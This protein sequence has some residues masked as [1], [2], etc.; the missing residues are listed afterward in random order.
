MSNPKSRT[1]CWTCRLRHKK[2]DGP[3]PVCQSCKSLQISCFYGHDKPNWMDNGNMQHNMAQQIKAEVRRSATQRRGRRLIQSIAQDMGDAGHDI[4]SQLDQ[5]RPSLA[6]SPTSVDAGSSA[7]AG[8]RQ[9]TAD[10]SRADFLFPN[11]SIPVSSQGG[12]VPDATTNSIP[13]VSLPVQNVQHPAPVIQNEL[14]LNLVMAYLDYVFPILFPFYRPS[15]LEGGRNWLLVLLMKNKGLCHTVISLTTYF[16]SIVPAIQGQAH[17]LCTPTMWEE[18][19]KQTDLAIKMMQNDLQ[20]INRQGVHSDLHE[21]A[22]LMESIVQLLGFE[23]IFT[24]TDSWQ[25]HLDAAIVLFVQIFQRHG[26]KELP[27]NISAILGQMGHKSFATITSNP[28]LPTL[29]N[30]DQ[31]AFRFFSAILLV[32]DIISSTSLEK[33]PRLH[34]YHAH[35]L[36]NDLNHDQ[37]VP[38]QIEDLV[39]C[40]SWAILLI[41][42][43]ATLDAW[44]KDMK[45]CDSLPMAQLVQRAGVIERHLYE[46]LERLDNPDSRQ[47]PSSKHFVPIDMLTQYKLYNHQ[48][49]KQDAC[50]SIT[51]IWAHAA[52]IYLHIV[53]SGWQPANPKVRR[54]VARTIELLKEL[55]SPG[56]LRTLAWP[57][58]VT[59]CLAEEGQEAMFRE[60][61][62]SMGALQ[63]FGT[64]RVALSIMETIWCCRTKINAESWD[65]A[66]CLNSLGRK[67]LLV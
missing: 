22:Y 2:C 1:G 47:R 31:A 52:Q 59:G 41:G 43:I 16:F 15:I 64:M 49:R 27:P 25:M 66:A 3:L 54:S 24:P 46:G 19:Q 37:E 7:L 29:W 8:D 56:W 60:I 18:L 23:V 51:R 67:V 9:R 35:L 42:E 65:I 14:Q 45:K 17:Q 40:E 11:V 12:D 38:L 26:K 48:P 50:I 34:E 57:L 32:D 58:C 61:V 44:K 33:A 13:E 21:S 62:G 5:G 4:L 20:E 36:S 39:G 6:S 53:V 63:M 28:T 10:N 30:A 55:D